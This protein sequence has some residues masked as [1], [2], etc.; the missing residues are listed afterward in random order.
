[1]DALVQRATHGVSAL[2][3]VSDLG[4]LQ[5][6][7]ASRTRLEVSRAIAVNYPQSRTN[8]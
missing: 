7:K 5:N 4:F 6:K 2:I 1:M 3:N 8:S